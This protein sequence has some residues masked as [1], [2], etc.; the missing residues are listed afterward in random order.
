MYHTLR[1]FPSSISQNNHFLNSNEGLPWRPVGMVDKDRKAHRQRAKKMRLGTVSEHHAHPHSV[2]C[3]SGLPGSQHRNSISD[4]RGLINCF[5]EITGSSKG[6]PP[7]AHAGSLSQC[8]SPGQS[9]PHWGWQGTQAMRGSLSD[10][11][12]RFFTSRFWCLGIGFVLLVLW[13]KF[14]A[15]ECNVFCLLPRQQ[16][17]RQIPFDWFAVSGLTLCPLEALQVMLMCSIT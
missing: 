15:P 6:K 13:I 3:E 5:L 10:C 16:S 14:R 9:L 4:T 17:T 12:G 1:W 8:S 11:L 2:S 7:P